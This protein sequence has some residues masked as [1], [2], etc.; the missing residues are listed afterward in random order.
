MPTESEFRACAR[1]LAGAADR[2]EGAFDEATAR[3]SSRPFTGGRLS[4]EVTELALSACLVLREQ[5]RQLRDVA[6]VCHV[7]AAAIAD[8]RSELAAYRRAQLD[9]D[10]A[11]AR[12]RRRVNAALADPD[13]P[14]AGP[15]P[16][17]PPA[18]DNPP[19]WVE[20]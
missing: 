16:V 15:S 3:L 4:D 1:A 14:P 9:Y 10:D 17:P 13:A 5:A 20:L 18:P 11:L 2:V 19:P 8:Y 12:W 7:R 6:L